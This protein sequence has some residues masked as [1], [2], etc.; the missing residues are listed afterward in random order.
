MTGRTAWITTSFLIISLALI[1]SPSEA[2]E[3]QLEFGTKGGSNDNLYSDSSKKYD[4]YST[5]TAQLSYHPLSSLQ[6]TLGGEHTYYREKTG[7]STITGQI[8][9]TYIPTPRTSPL[10]V[11]LSG[12][13]SGTRY[14]HPSD[15][16][17]FNNNYAEISLSMGYD[18]TDIIS[19]RVGISQNSSSYLGADVEDKDELQYFWGGNITLPGSVSLDVE[20]GFAGA[21]YSYIFGDTSDPLVG[22]ALPDTMPRFSEKLQTFY[23]SPRI[24][25]TI[26]PKT[27]LSI[28]YTRRKFQNYDNQII[29]GYSTQFLSPWASVW[30][31]KSVTAKLKSY[32]IPRLIITAGA[33]YWDKTFM[34][35]VQPDQGFYIQVVTDPINRRQDWQ[36]KFYGNIQWPISFHSGLFIE[37]N[38]RVDYTRN[39]SNRPL[40]FYNNF[41]FSVMVTIR[42]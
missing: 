2:S 28:V 38:I 21:D 26:A 18:I 42:L 27:G 17:D 22:I 36:T 6:I 31:G 15:L 9:V 3:F 16:P 37:P 12:N 41:A 19:A 13:L 20:T 25:R 39:K 35:T 11:N 14:Y 34:K 7:L 10:A 5:S 8:G 33:G 23:Y 32:I 40:F 24:S 4:T 1:S 30:E 29:L